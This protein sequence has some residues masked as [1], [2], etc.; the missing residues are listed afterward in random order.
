MA[1]LATLGFVASAGSLFAQA[2]DSGV[3]G[4][5]DWAKS[6]VRFVVKLEQ[7]THAKHSGLVDDMVDE[8]RA[9]APYDTGLLYAGIEKIDEGDVIVFQASASR[10]GGADYARFVEFG[11]HAG[12]AGVFAAQEARDGMFADP[13]ATSETVTGARRRRALRTHGGSPAQP[14]YFPA[15]RSVLDRAGLDFADVIAGAASNASL[16][17]E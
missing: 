17:T 11:T 13:A 12:Q 15:I 2:H 16:N 6:L 3:L 10:D 1:S 7:H 8:A 4:F 14:Y 9:E 5:D